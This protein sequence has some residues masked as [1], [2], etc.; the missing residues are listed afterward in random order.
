MSYLFGFNT[1]LL[2]MPLITAGYAALLADLEH[3]GLVYD[4]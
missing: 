1:F 3:L 4:G 2:I